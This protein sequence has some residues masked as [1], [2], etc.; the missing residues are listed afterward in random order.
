MRS[1]RRAT[2]PAVNGLLKEARL[3]MSNSRKAAV[4]LDRDGTII[5]DSGYLRD[6]SDV[7]F[8]PG[9]FKALEKLKDRFLLFIVT[10]Q[11]GVAK[12]LITLND[13]EQINRRVVAALAERGIELAD[14][15]VCPH[16]RAD[17]CRCI[18]PKPYFLQRAAER[19]DIDLSASFT[20]GDHP[21]DVQLAR[22]AGAKGIYV[23]T[24]HGRK[25][26]AEL[27]ENVVIASGMA[28]A[29]ETILSDSF[30][31]DLYRPCTL[32]EKCFVGF[33][34]KVFDAEIADGTFIGTG[35]IVQ[36]VQ[37]APKSLVPPGVSA[38]CREH[39]IRL[40]GTTGPEERKFAERVVD[41]NLALAQGYIDLND[42]DRK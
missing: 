17:N 21:H 22:N 9:T 12:G 30:N 29:A 28:E 40:V 34:A 7:V 32:G 11:T 42:S 41:A 4:F 2:K 15:Y 10:N 16:R 36:G 39:V 3:V 31:R 6:P 18:K 5:E 14:I 20:V 13:V 33:G 35:A 1:A 8:Y 27:P 23:L 24:G 26:R 37:L 25:H 19:Y 38:L